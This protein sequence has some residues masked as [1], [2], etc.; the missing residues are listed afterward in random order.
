VH[1]SMAIFDQN[2]SWASERMVNLVNNTCTNS[3]P[4]SQRKNSKKKMRY[5]EGGQHT[6]PS[7]ECSI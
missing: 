5:V 6:K 3:N 4:V 2:N 7:P 1:V